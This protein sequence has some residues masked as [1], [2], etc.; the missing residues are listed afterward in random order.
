MKMA[1]F[2]ASFQKKILTGL[3]KSA[4][5]GYVPVKVNSVEENFFLVGKGLR[6]GDLFTM[7][8]KREWADYRSMPQ[9]CS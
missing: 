1:I 5:G 8:V 3:S 9:V 2:F 6:Q 4:H 7:I